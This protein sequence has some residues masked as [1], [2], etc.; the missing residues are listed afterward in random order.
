MASYYSYETAKILDDFLLQLEKEPAVDDALLE[1][2]RQMVRWGGLIIFHD[3]VDWETLKMEKVL[4]DNRR[5]RQRIPEIDAPRLHCGDFMVKGS[6]ECSSS[7]TIRSTACCL[8]GL[9]VLPGRL[10][11]YIAL[12]ASRQGSGKA[13]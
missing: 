6:S 4:V 8:T 12:I 9:S 3:D 10:T 1:E 7:E 5:R 13:G 2:L 11:P